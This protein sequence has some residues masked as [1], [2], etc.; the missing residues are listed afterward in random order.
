MRIST[1][2]EE[3]KGTQKLKTVHIFVYKPCLFLLPVRTK[4]FMWVPMLY[5]TTVHVY[6]TYNM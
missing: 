2:Q 4:V 1:L 3:V 6:I 5:V